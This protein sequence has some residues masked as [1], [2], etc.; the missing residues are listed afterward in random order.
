MNDLEGQVMLCVRSMCGRFLETILLTVYL[1]STKAALGR[2]EI[3]GSAP[4]VR[5]A[6]E[7]SSILELMTR[8]GNETHRDLI[9]KREILTTVT[10]ILSV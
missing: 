5:D 1:V 4:V 6:R 9:S 3:R 8:H 10:G 2:L 7:S